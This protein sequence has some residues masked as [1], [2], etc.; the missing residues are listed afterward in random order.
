VKGKLLALL[1]LAGGSLFAGSHV[2]F[3]VGVGVYGGGY[4]PGY[5]APPPPPPAAAYYP[6][7]PGPGYSWVGGYY[8][9]VGPRYHW[10]AGY[11][12]PRPY[13]GAY[14]V[15]PRYYGRRYYR[16]YWRR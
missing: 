4:Y 3:G 11:W 14:W 6:A 1:L 2:F 9:P 13:V 16:G 12:T 15:A 8:Y 10:R 7:A 5:Y